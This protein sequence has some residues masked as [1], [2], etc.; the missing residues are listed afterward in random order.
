M[1]ASKLGQRLTGGI[2]AS[3]L[4]KGDPAAAVPRASLLSTRTAAAPAR[5]EYVT[6]PLIGRVYIQLLGHHVS[7]QV[8]GEV[9]EAMASAK[10]PPVPLH[11]W[12]YDMQRQARTLARAARD[13]DDHSQPFGPVEEWLDLDDDLLFACGRVYADV[14]ERL[15]PV[16]AAF[17][18]P[19]TADEITEAFKKKDAST[20]RSHGVVSLVSWLLSGAVQLS[21]SQTPASSTSPSDSPDDSSEAP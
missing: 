16:G 9:F 4:G 18:A 1:T 10:L 11:A 20:L 13:P 15:D 7:N 8:E 2:P 12:S 5:G 6:L 21:S 14:K 3:A 19:E 17:L